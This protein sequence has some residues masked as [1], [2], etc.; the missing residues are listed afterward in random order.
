MPPYAAAGPRGS[1][2]PAAALA[3][4][5]SRLWLLVRHLAALLPVTLLT[6]QQTF[7]GGRAPVAWAVRG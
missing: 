6:A 1:A 3:A 5:V 2:R 4:P 7:A